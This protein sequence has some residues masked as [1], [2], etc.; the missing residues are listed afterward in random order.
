MTGMPVF[1]SAAFE[2]GRRQ[3]G[4]R[5]EVGFGWRDWPQEWEAKDQYSLSLTKSWIFQ[6]MSIEDPCSVVP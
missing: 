3:H 4:V 6:L 2:P 5:A 1:G